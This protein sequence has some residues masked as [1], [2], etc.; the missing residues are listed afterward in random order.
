MV[1]GGHQRLRLTIVHAWLLL[2]SFHIHLS[3]KL[4]AISPSGGTTITQS[5]KKSHVPFLVRRLYSIYIFTI[6]LI[7]CVT[8]TKPYQ[9]NIYV[10]WYRNNIYICVS[11]SHVTRLWGLCVSVSPLT[12]GLYVW[13]AR[14]HCVK[15]GCRWS[16]EEE[17]GSPQGTTAYWLHCG[18][19]PMYNSSA[20]YGMLQGPGPPGIPSL[21]LATIDTKTSMICN[22]TTS[23]RWPE[24]Y[25]VPTHTHIICSSVN[26]Q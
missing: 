7:V 3:M 4:S 14:R 20:F 19:L 9:F 15:W 11:L 6:H 23:A 18:Q 5:I 2:S 22:K 24:T 17:A 1:L 25:T 16:R 8:E 12:M 21:S 26:F 10:F 13:V